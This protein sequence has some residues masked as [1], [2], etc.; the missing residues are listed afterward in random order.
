MN[1]KKRQRQDR[2]SRLHSIQDKYT[3]KKPQLVWIWKP[4]EINN[5]E[6]MKHL[7]P[8]CIIEYQVLGNRRF[9]PLEF[10][11]FKT[12]QC[13]AEIEMLQKIANM[14]CFEILSVF[15]QD[16]ETSQMELIWTKPVE[17]DTWILTEE[18]K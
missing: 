4:R 17:E 5:E 18:D 12:I 3:P 11:E 9:P 2:T 8:G 1:L 13:Q 16:N 10:T 7:K 15:Y 14:A 6:A